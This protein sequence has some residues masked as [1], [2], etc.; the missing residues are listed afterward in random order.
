MI[1]D[2][3]GHL[4]SYDIC[5]VQADRLI[6]WIYA[7]TMPGSIEGG[8]GISAYGEILLQKHVLKQG[9]VF[10]KGVLNFAYKN[11]LLFHWQH[12]PGDFSSFIHAKCVSKFLGY[13]RII[14]H[15]ILKLWV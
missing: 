13:Y 10:V 1:P 11:S 7:T 12:N 4:F 9:E 15:N 8:Y 14:N 2:T 3:G 6:A 5:E